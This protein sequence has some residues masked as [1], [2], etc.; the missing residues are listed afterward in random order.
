MKELACDV[1]ALALATGAF[2]RDNPDSAGGAGF[3]RR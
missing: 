3:L 2:A 1:V